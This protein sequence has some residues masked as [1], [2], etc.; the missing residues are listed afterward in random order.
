MRITKKWLIILLGI[1]ITIGLVIGLALGVNRIGNRLVDYDNTPADSLHVS[2]STAGFFALSLFSGYDECSYFVSDLKEMAK[3]MANV[4]IE[5]KSHQYYHDD[6]FTS[7][8]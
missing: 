5:R 1:F 6:Y 4:H 7:L 2:L 3:Y 8:P